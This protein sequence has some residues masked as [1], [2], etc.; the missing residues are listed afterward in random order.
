MA[1]LSRF[2]LPPFR[3]TEAGMSPE[4][5][6]RSQPFEQTFGD[7]K[8]QD[9]NC[10]S[11]TSIHSTERLCSI[12]QFVGRIP[13]RTDAHEHQTLSPL[14]DRRRSVHLHGPSLWCF[15]CPL[16]LHTSDGHSRFAST[17]TDSIR[18][19]QLSRQLFAEEP[20]SDPTLQRSVPLLSPPGVVG[21]S[22]IRE[23]SSLLPSQSFFHL[24]MKF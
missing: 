6:H 5:C 9:G 7:S 8:V 24:G 20:G 19:V 4:T 23:K 15:H 10:E 22:G 2:L 11:S 17:S 16:G 1:Q 14:R 21:I 13:S 18:S 3:R 12:D